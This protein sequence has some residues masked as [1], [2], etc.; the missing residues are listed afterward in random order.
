M[1]MPISLD[2]GLI[3]DITDRVEKVGGD[4]TANREGL[5][6]LARQLLQDFVGAGATGYEDIVRELNTRLTN[7]ENNLSRLNGAIV[8][9]KDYTHATDVAQGNRFRH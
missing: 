7:Y 5:E 2:Y 6:Q 8:A 3:A 4:M 1:S 9:A